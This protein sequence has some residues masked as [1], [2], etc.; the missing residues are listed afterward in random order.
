MI[1]TN[2]RINH[3]NYSPALNAFQYFNRD[4]KK[5]EIHF[6]KMKCVQIKRKGNI[7]ASQTY[8]ANHITSS[9]VISFVMVNLFLGP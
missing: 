8:L 1:F 5:A 6:Y 4:K 9:I 2:I 3:K 7:N